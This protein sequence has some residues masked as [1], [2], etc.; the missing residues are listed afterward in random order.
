MIGEL[1]G[2]ESESIRFYFDVL[3]ED[4]VAKGAEL[5]FKMIKAQFKCRQCGNIFERA[6]FT[7]NCPVCG[8]TG[9]LVDKGKEFYIES[10][11]VE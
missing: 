10:I 8:A 2:L 9:V 5:V 11:E 6:N 4:T 1:T 7:F 3:S